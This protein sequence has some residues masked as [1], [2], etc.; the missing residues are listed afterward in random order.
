MTTLL[1]QIALR[2][3]DFELSIKSEYL[4]Q[5]NRHYEGWIR[6]YRMGKI[7]VVESDTLD[8]VN[9]G[10]DLEK[11]IDMIREELR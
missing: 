4:E 3:R 11:I 2:G 10:E 1:H 5:L 7:L 8:F 9:N 6:R